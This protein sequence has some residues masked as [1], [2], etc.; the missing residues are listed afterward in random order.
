MHVLAAG[1]ILAC[2]Q[3]PKSWLQTM[4]TAKRV[5]RKIVGKCR[6]AK[7]K[8]K[9]PDDL[10]G[11]RTYRTEDGSGLHVCGAAREVRAFAGSRLGEVPEPGIA[12]TPED[13]ALLSVRL[14]DTAIGRGLSLAAARAKASGTAFGHA[15]REPFAA[16]LP[17]LHG[18]PC[19]PS[20]RSAAG[21]GIQK[22]RTPGRSQAASMS[23]RAHRSALLAAIREYPRGAPAPELA[24]R[25]AQLT[26]RRD[27]DFVARWPHLLDRLQRNDR[28]PHLAPIFPLGPLGVDGNDATVS[29]GAELPE[30]IEIFIETGD[31]VSEKRARVAARGHK[32]LHRAVLLRQVD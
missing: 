11:A 7:C 21:S 23:A 20:W 22:R 12:G 9:L 3:I 15:P 19:R 17:T 27:Y 26:P 1:R 10:D 16:G 18:D 8:Q 30:G 5:Q 28:R 6:I 2:G 4:Y 32:R 24:P 13:A 14:A 29:H 31:E 25:T